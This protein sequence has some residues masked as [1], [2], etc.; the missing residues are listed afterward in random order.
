MRTFFF[1][2]RED[3]SRLSAIIEAIFDLVFQSS[4]FLKQE[5]ENVQSDD[6]QPRDPSDLINQLEAQAAIMKGEAPAAASGTAPAPSA[7]ESASPAPE[8]AGDADTGRI[9]VFF[10]NEC[11][12]EN[13]RAFALMNQLKDICE[14]LD[15]DPPHPEKDASCCGEIIK[16]GFTIIFKPLE[17]MDEVIKVIEDS[18]NIKSYEILEQ[19]APAEASAAAPAPEAPPAAPAAPTPPPPAAPAAP[20]PAP[21]AKPAAAPASTGSSAAKAGTKQNLL[22]VNQ[23]KLDHLMDLVGELVTAESMVAGSPDLRGLKLDNFT[24]SFRELR[25]LTDEL[26]DVVMS[27]RMVP[28][29]G[30][31]QKMNRIVRDM[32]KKTRQTRRTGHRGRGNRG[33]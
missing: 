1:L 5:I 2:I 14:T 6:Y 12:M 8:P 17:V 13:I 23:S 16:N 28:L 22:S 21:A 30:T 3:P 9:R 25:K 27:I 4:D 15:S 10:D 19:S 18:L 32:S 24:K 20:A 11:Q 26:Q 33:G 7:D 31:F 29:T